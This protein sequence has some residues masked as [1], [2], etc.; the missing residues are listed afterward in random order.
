[1]NAEGLK[2]TSPEPH[3]GHYYWKKKKKS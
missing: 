2:T 1:L 3:P